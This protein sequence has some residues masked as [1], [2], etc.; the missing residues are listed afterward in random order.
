[1]E[2]VTP[3]IGLL[4]WM[5]ISFTIVFL[6]LKKFAWKPIINA[7]K[8]RED[9]IT[10]AL[11]SAQKARKDVEGLKA[12]NEK[13][14]AEARREKD[15][16]L[17]EARDIKEK[18]VAEAKTQANAETQKSIETARLIIQN[19]KTAAI[20]EIKQQVAELSVSIAEKVLQ[21]ELKDK[22]EQEALVD[23]LLKDVKLQ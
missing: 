9:S 19:E 23:N 7:L 13:I 3:G 22:K 15:L 10:E 18:I 8:D 20:N 21:K 17:K 12:D 4:F 11:N 16:I 5:A 6:I 2:L 1:M 14:I